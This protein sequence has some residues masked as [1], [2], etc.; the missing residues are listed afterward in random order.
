MLAEGKLLPDGYTL[1]TFFQT[2]GRGQAG[3]SWESEQGKNLLFS[4][5]IRPDN[6]L[7]GNQFCLSMFVALTITNVINRLLMPH[8]L[9]ATI[10]W[11]NDIYVGDKKLVGILI[12]NSLAGSCVDTSIAGIG[13]NVN[14]TVF[15]SDAPNPVSLVQLTGETYDLHRL[16]QLV[17]EEF[18]QL[19]YLL[20]EPAKL[21]SLYMQNLYRRHG[22]HP[23]VEREV[24]VVP[25]SIVQQTDDCTFLA[26]IVDIDK[27]GCL[28]LLLSTG[29]T[30]HYHFKQ[31]RYV[32]PTT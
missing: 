24:S 26:E 27:S 8:G 30:K 22:F 31:I 23:Y 17:S 32:I 7:A 13:I 15:L 29:E 21:K 16:M 4:T 19:K 6:I 11:P 14:Q 25:T 10:K 20:S 3:N 12:E 2:A 1:Y 18:A 5:L 9:S 28:C